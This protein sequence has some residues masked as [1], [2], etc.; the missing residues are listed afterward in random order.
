MSIEKIQSLGNKL[1]RT[2]KAIRDI[3]D[4]AKRTKDEL[5]ILKCEIETELLDL[6]TEAKIGSIKTESGECYAKSKRN[7]IGIISMPHALKFAKDNDCFTL[8]KRLVEQ[9]LKNVE[10]LP[11][12]FERKIVEFISVRKPKQEE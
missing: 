12:C 11:E 7:S 4:E 9:A 8:D 6:M 5:K 10:E 2:R 1:G 3:E